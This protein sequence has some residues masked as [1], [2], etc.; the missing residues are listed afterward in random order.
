MK[1][2]WDELV[3]KATDI[4]LLITMAFLCANIVVLTIWFF[5]YLFTGSK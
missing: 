2:T 5:V 4:S 3:H 1:M